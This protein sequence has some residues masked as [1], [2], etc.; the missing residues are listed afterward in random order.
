MHQSKQPYQMKRQ[1]T[2]G[3]ARPARSRAINTT[4]REAGCTS[5]R[6]ASSTTGKRSRSRERP[7]LSKPAN[8]R[9]TQWAITPRRSPAAATTITTKASASN[10]ELECDIPLSDMTATV[11]IMPHKYKI[12]WHNYMVMIPRLVQPKVAQLLEE[13]PAV[14]LLGPRQVGKTTLALSLA[15][16]VGDSAPYLELE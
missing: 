1:T 5:T 10:S 4:T 14:A 9:L 3:S 15:E 6:K 11:E 16:A 12:V 8:P 2:S 13:F 7:P